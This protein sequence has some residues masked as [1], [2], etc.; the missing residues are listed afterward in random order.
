[1]PDRIERFHQLHAAGTFVIPNPWDPGSAHL[2]AALGFPALATT[3]SG[4]A[5]SMA[6]RD[7]GLS[8][9]ETLDHLRAITRTVSIPVNADFEAGF[10][11][12]P[13]DVYTNVLAATTTGVAGLS[14]E[15]STGNPTTPLFDFDLAVAR[16]AAARHAI[17]DSRTGV[18]LT[19]R[20]EGFIVH[21]RRRLP[22]RPRH[23]HHRRHLRRRHRRRP[24][25]RQRPR[26][27][28][29]HHRRRPRR[30]R[31]PPHQRRR[32]TRP[33]RLDRL[34]DRRH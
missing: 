23:P 14:I 25:T 6:R 32:R 13:D 22:L 2:L 17:D 15:D 19:A 3:S 10:A 21:R 27:L 4:H 5:W 26:Q 18:L 8:L 20:T 16:I 11:I 31:R 9:A 29:L 24:Q 34:H 30:P 12:T 28:R 1:M 33:R 7:N